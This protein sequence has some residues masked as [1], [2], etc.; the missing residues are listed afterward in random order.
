MSDVLVIDDES[1]VRQ[2]V[3]DTLELAGYRVDEA[4][5]GT[6]GLNILKKT[7]PSIVICDLKMPGLNGFE[8]LKAI[9]DCGEQFQNLSFIFLSGLTDK[10][11]VRAG[12][13]IGADDFIAKPL[14][15]DLLRLKVDALMRKTRSREHSERDR[16]TSLQKSGCGLT[17]KT[18]RVKVDRPQQDVSTEFQNRLQKAILSGGEVSSGSCQF[19]GFDELK[20]AFGQEWEQLR[21]RAISMC[22]AII[23]SELGPDDSF[24]RFG[25]AG[26]LMLFEGQ[27]EAQARVCVDKI[28]GLIRKRLLG[29][30]A[31]A[32]EYLQIQ[33]DVINPRSFIDDDGNITASSLVSVFQG[34]EEERASSISSNDPSW[35]TKQLGKIYRPL[36]DVKREVI[37]ASQIY[38]TRDTSYGT[39]RGLA[40]L[41]GGADDPLAI[42]LDCFLAEQAA[43][44]LMESLQ[45]NTCR[46]I[47]LPIYFRSLINEE[48]ETLSE[49]L[50]SVPESLRAR[51][52]SLE[53]VGVPESRDELTFQHA[54]RNAQR[55]SKQ[56]V[57]ELPAEDRH[58]F[59]AKA[60]RVKT[61]KLEI[62][63][64]LD[65][66]GKSGGTS[67]IKQFCQSAKSNYFQT[68][69]DN[70]NCIDSFDTAREFGAEV[71]GGRTI[72]RSVKEPM[73]PTFLALSK[74]LSN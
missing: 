45:S 30:S 60:Q 65:P 28:S 73:L 72:G 16:A 67:R 47:S 24:M 44:A 40:C 19:V 42:H 49:V 50:A 54:I 11:C 48:Y 61:I 14:D 57:V 59:V 7:C 36:W 20:D 27:D 64:K 2:L 53:V 38:P 37:T 13:K 63:D 62:D 21:N 18:P 33:T 29:D 68:R 66:S 4:N 43:S 70:I 32:Q 46:P 39:L 31:D 1:G 10:D 22:E 5:N 69:V 34:R 52:L 71:I 51:Q 15:I 8:V 6:S 41:H 55:L 12:Y 26:F 35:F 9:R 23:R 3:R 74:I 58:A 17:D 25:D 56:V